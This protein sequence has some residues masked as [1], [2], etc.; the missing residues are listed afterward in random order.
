MPFHSAALNLYRIQPD[1]TVVI[2]II[3]ILP[4]YV[5]YKVDFLP[6][7]PKIAPAGLPAKAIPFFS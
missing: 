5:N 7:L 4:N 2:P 6:V 3:R 1:K